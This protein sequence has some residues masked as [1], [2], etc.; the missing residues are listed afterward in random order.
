MRVDGHEFFE[1]NFTGIR[2][3]GSASESPVFLVFPSQEKEEQVSKIVG[4][5]SLVILIALSVVGA[6]SETPGS[7][8]HQVQTLP[9]WFPIVAGF[10]SKALAKWAAL[11]CMIFWLVIMIFIWL[12]LL[13]L[14]SPVSG[15]FNP[16]EIVMTLVVGVA[17]L[18][19]LAVCF[20]WR[21]SVA[22]S[23]SACVFLLFA[24]LQ[25]AAMAASLTP[26]I[27]QR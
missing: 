9:L 8:R 11:P 26:Y 18:A 22:L 7:L 24:A 16:T 17:S 3:G 10:Q 5:C 1:G 12:F 25:V 19:G 21:T 2:R 6:V 20:R 13:G 14:P 23:V 27:A 4:Y 15:T